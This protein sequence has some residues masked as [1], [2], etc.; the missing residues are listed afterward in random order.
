MRPVRL[1]LDTSDYAAMYLA[2][3]GTPP[4]RVRAALKELA[5]SGRIEIGLSYHV[6]FELLQKAEP[7]YRE[8]RLARA[9]LLTELCGRNAFPYPTDLGQGQFSTEGLWVPRVDL[10]D[11]EIERVVDY[12]M[13]GIA[14][15]PELNRR[16]RRI[17]S[18]RKNFTRWMVGNA[19]KAKVLAQQLWPLKFG[20]TFV[21]S[22][23]L[24]CYLS[25]EMTRDDANK[26]LWFFITD[27]VSVYEV[28]FE[29][30]GRDDPIA[31]RRDRIV[32]TFVKMGEQFNTMLND[33][34]NFQA[35]VKEAIAATGDDALTPAERET[36]IK[37]R[38]QAK[39]FRTEM[40]SAQE[41]Y[42][43]VPVWK[44]Y[45]GDQAAFVAAQ[46]L[47][48]FLREKRAIKQ[49][50]GIDFVHAMYLPY[51]DLWRGDKA[52]SD[53]LTK[54]GV[55]FSERVVPTL[56]DLPDRIEAEMTRLRAGSQS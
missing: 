29:Q 20:R 39:T 1:H 9:R 27:P 45:F 34:V 10:E 8:D 23:D 6:V 44:E 43:R 53:L 54:H 38:A 22:G 15:H 7:R 37:L 17:L 16:E 47:H 51:T 33:G 14:C 55:N 32:R 36:L 12:L 26:K 50:D 56:L 28:W 48:A 11:V 24:T 41:L 2:G 31:E 5:H 18:K 13:K 52:F 46:I 3:P 25:G 21:E 19:T 49:S 40:M 30:Y 42:E 35:K 4:A